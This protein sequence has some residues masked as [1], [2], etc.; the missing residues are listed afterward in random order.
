MV[1][2]SF[3]VSECNTTYEFRSRTIVQLKQISDYEGAKAAISQIYLSCLQSF[4]EKQVDIRFSEHKA[5]TPEYT[6]KRLMFYSVM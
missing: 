5:N 3:M 4:F 6:I 2:L 1:S